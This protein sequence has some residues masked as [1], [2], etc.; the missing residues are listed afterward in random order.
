MDIYLKKKTS[1]GLWW[2]VSEAVKF[3]KAVDDMGGSA[4]FKGTKWVALYD[5]FDVAAQ[6]N[7]SAKLGAVRL[8]AS[9]STYHGPDP[10]KLHIHLE[11]VVPSDK[12][13][14]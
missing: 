6:V 14:P 7:K 8:R 9:G 3:L 10:A 5:H 1:D 12:D 13:K 4:D 2:D 11:V